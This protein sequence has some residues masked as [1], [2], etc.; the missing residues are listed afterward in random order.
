MKRFKAIIKN[1][2][3]QVLLAIIAGVC[4]GHF[5]PAIGVKMEIIGNGFISIIK[6]FI[7]PIIFLTITLG[8]A[9][10]GDIKKVGRIG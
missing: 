1:L 8:I 7:A 10:I 2:A 9:G 6:V 3:F 5:Y 4:L